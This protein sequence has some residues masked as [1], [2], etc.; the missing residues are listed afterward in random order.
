MVGV[1]AIRR[2][3]GE[4][5]DIRKQGIKNSRMQPT[6]LIGA[7]QAGVIV[8]REIAARPDLQIKPIGFIDD[9]QMKQG[10]RVHGLK[11]LGT[12]NDLESLAKEHN[13]QAALIT[14][15]NT[16]ETPIRRI[17][18]K[19][20]EANLNTKIIPCIYCLLYTSPSPRDQR[21][22]RMPSSA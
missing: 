1:R 10:T 16:K 2:T 8:A 14:I 21:G 22:S 5:R 6:L 12:V 15:A 7:G 18:Q 11:V 13:A 3:F 20:R 4:K 9:D 19:C 17:A